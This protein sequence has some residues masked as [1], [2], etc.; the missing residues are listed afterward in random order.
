MPVNQGF[1]RASELGAG[2]NDCRVGVIGEAEL[3]GAAFMA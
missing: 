2:A 3:E 1:Q